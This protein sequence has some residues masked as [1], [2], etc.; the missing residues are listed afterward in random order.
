MCKLLRRVIANAGFLR[1]FPSLHVPQVLTSGHFWANALG[2]RK[3][4]GGINFVPSPP[5]RRAIHLH[6]CVSLD[7]LARPNEAVQ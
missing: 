7:F 2:T 3:Q 4:G 6:L 5:C 1:R